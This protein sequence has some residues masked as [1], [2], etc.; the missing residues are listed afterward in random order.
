MT[1]IGSIPMP[2]M[3]RLIT[4]LAMSWLAFLLAGCGESPSFR[5]ADITTG[6]IG[7]GWQLTDH[8]GKPASLD[9]FKGKV[10][11]V[12][13][14]FTQ[15]PDICPASLSEVHN[16]LS[17]LGDDA[18]DVQVLMITV[19]PERDLP[20]IMK[21]YL[22]AF[23]EGIPTEFLGLTG[24]PEEVRQAAKAFRAYYAK[25]PTPD[26]SYTMDHSASF[27]LIDKAGKARV[28]LSNQSGPEAMAHDIKALL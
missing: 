18:K 6:D 19:D 23:N 26:G 8:H 28:L 2:G 4:W 16:V 10:T 24:T 13:F 11:L 27:Y 7:Q 22:Q 9:R 25:V 17:Q 5:G 21:S 3:R 14:G 12:F 1:S 20:A 15:C